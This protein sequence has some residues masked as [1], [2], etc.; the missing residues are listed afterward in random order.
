VEARNLPEEGNIAVVQSSQGFSASQY[1]SQISQISATPAPFMSQIAI[2]NQGAAFLPRV[3][4]PEPV[5]FPFSSSI[6]QAERSYSPR[7][8][9]QQFNA[10]K[11]NKHN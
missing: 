10:S 8:P 6:A 1:S 11:F 9:R 4:G 3:S 2:G 5:D 7:L